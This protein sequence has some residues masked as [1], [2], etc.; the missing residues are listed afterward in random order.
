MSVGFN[1]SKFPEF[2]DTDPDF[3]I[4]YVDEMMVGTVEVA[5]TLDDSRRRFE[6]KSGGGNSR[7]G[8]HYWG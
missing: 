4:F 5:D 7:R 1:A 8:N 2:A 3:T 6:S